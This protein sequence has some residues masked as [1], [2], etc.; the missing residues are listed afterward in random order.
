MFHPSNCSQRRICGTLERVRQKYTFLEYIEKQLIKN[1]SGFSS[2]DI[3]A[4]RFS[5]G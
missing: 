5:H 1:V 4:L 3:E 2:I